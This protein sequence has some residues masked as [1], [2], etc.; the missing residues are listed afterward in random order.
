MRRIP[1]QEE[2]D[3]KEGKQGNGRNWR[4]KRKSGRGGGDGFEVEIVGD[5]G[6]E[7]K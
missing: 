1:K 4:I 6:I 2:K 3:F 7:G 5:R